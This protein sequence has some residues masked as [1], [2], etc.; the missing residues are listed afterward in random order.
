MRNQSDENGRGHIINMASMAGIAPVPGLAIYSASKFALR[1]YSHAIANELKQ[2]A[3][4]ITVV[5]PAGADTPLVQPYKHKAEAALIFIGPL[6][7]IEQVV[8]AIV[9]RALVKRPAE[10]TL[11]RPR[12]VLAKLAGAWPGVAALLVGPMTR[13]GL[14]NQAKVK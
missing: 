11:P 2:H 9:D 8:H 7:T 4:S 6:L 13:S 5:C 1:G 3:I 14:R 12:G 10:I